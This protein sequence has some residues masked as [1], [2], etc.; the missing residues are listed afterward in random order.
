M[1][2]NCVHSLS[3][4]SN[5]NKR[6]AQT[7]PTPTPATGQLSFLELSNAVVIGKN[8]DDFQKNFLA[9][10]DTTKEIR[11]MCNELNS[12][13]EA[14]NPLA[15]FRNEK[16]LA[17]KNRQQ[18]FLLHH[19]LNPEYF[20]VFRNKVAVVWEEVSGRDPDT[21]S[22]DM[23]ATTMFVSFSITYISGVVDKEFGVILECLKQNSNHF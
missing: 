17:K 12:S 16:F 18:K 20:D 6:K 23:L 10:K 14:A 9:S 21:D 3:A 8:I 5:S 22:V 19:L 1:V 7:P 11:E 2:L 13:L 4:A 15:S